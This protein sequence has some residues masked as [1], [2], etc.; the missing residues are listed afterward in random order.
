M[1]A[2]R[3]QTDEIWITKTPGSM[4]GARVDATHAAEITVTYV[5][6]TKLGVAPAPKGWPP[7]TVLPLSERFRITDEPDFWAPE[8]FLQQFRLYP[9][10]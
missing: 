7:E 8:M 4:L 9:D 5:L 3:P 1:S 6:V 2:F 10:N